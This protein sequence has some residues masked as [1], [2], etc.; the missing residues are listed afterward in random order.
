MSRQ[1]L[2]KVTGLLPRAKADFNVPPN[3]IELEELVRAHQIRPHIG[4]DDV[5]VAADQRVFAWLF[6]ALPRLFDP[7]AAPLGRHFRDGTHRNEPRPVPHISN[8][9]REVDPVAF[10]LAQ[11]VLEFDLLEVP[12]LHIGGQTAQPP[13]LEVFDS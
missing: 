10:G 2:R 9:H 13:G 5:P 3:R 6:S 12:G 7:F 11:D 4:D 8:V 1:S